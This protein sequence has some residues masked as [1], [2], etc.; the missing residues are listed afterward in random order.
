MLSSRT[1]LLPSRR[2]AKIAV[3]PASVMSVLVITSRSMVK[4]SESIYETQPGGVWGVIS[5]KLLACGGGSAVD[6]ARFLGGAAL[7]PLF[8]NLGG[9]QRTTTQPLDAQQ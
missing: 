9:A 8:L 7:V 3:N 4:L 6:H 1:V 2:T 5:F